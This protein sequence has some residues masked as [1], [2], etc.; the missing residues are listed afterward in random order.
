MKFNQRFRML[1]AG[2]VLVGTVL[3]L[4]FVF[5][6]TQSLL[7]VWARLQTLPSWLFYTYLA[8][9]LG[10][11]F[12]SAWV[13]YK[14][15]FPNRSRLAVNQAPPTAESLAQE[16]EQ[17]EDTGI[18]MSAIRAE[19][20]KL[21]QRK[22]AGQIHI[23]FY[24]DVSTGKSSIIKAL[25]P[26]ANVEINI[27]GGSTR[28][29][30]EYRWTSS[31]GDQLLLTDL[32][33]RNEAD[34]ELD[35]VAL[36]EA[37]RAQ[38]VVYVT[39]SDL[40]RTQFN[41]IITL[42][43][44][45]KPTIIAVNKSDLYTPEEQNQIRTQ[46]ESRF[47]DQGPKVVFVQSG[48]QEEV[49]RITP[50]GHEETFM[51][52]RK[53]KIE[54]LAK[55]IQTIIDDRDELLGELR[56]ASVFSLV[57]Q[58][59]DATKRE[60]RHDQGKK[61]VHTSTRN[62]VLG[63]MAAMAPGTDIVIQGIIGT[64]MVQEL[65]KLYDSPVSQLDLDDFLDFSQNQVK[66]TLPLILAV[67]GNGLKA[68]P[69]LGTVAGG[70]VHAVAY[71]LIFDALGNAVLHTLEQRGELKAAPAAIT[72]REMLS[73]NLEE[74]TKTFARLVIDHYKSDSSAK[75]EDQRS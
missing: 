65:C 66:K 3:L 42:Y 36:D 11:I 59:L 1:L 29:I 5:F 70:L 40:S 41:D 60:H 54:A 23:A 22:A 49:V 33:G 34:G 13:I 35:Q 38:I 44:F 48:G 63:A 74:R 71:G 24:G 32:P 4:L 9:I 73:G 2:A 67:I 37:V 61:I 39:D 10:V 15:M 21:Q 55:A 50:E 43:Q 14:L 30:A 16:I 12:S 31:A 69:G 6:A 25:L 46:I 53:I 47:E 62:A 8:L 26:E 68:F 57:K 45:N 72:F 18:D 27:R 58:K 7:D 51:R 28:E 20:A 75:Q 17:V 64:R 56:D 19:L 52:P